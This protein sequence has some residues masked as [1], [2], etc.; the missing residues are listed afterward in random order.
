MAKSISGEH[1]TFALRDSWLT[2]GYQAVVNSN[3]GSIFSS[4]DATIAH[5]AG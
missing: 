2:K 3:D 4:D 1:E 5:G